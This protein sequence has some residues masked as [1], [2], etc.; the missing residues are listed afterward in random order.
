M[1]LKN[2]SIWKVI[3]DFSFD[4]NKGENF[5]FKLAS[6][7]HWSNSY[8]EE[9]IGEYKKFLYLCAITSEELVP[10]KAVDMAWTIHMN[11]FASNYR[12][13]CLLIPPYLIKRT[14]LIIPAPGEGSFNDDWF[15]TQYSNTQ[16]IYKEVFGQLPPV[17]I[18]TNYTEELNKYKPAR[19]NLGRNM[20]LELDYRYVCIF[21]LLAGVLLFRIYRHPLPVILG[22]VLAALYYFYHRSVK[23]K[24]DR[25]YRQQLRSDEPAL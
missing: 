22:G 2:H 8:T 19:I 7:G 12:E 10:P 4:T 23:K 14:N 17:N 6:A 18:W 16:K 20:N 9:V 21:I 11:E 5:S 1:Q 3:N 15:T 13:L 24:Y 25:G